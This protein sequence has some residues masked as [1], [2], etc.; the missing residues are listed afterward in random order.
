MAPSQSRHSGEHRQAA[1]P[2]AAIIAAAGVLLAGAALV[3]FLIR[4]EAREPELARIVLAQAPPA[5]NG[6]GGQ[7]KY[8]PASEEI[9]TTSVL[10]AAGVRVEPR[11][12]ETLA[13][14]ISTA[15]PGFGPRLNP[16]RS[17][18][19]PAPVAEAVEYSREPRLKPSG[20]RVGSAQGAD[21]EGA[22]A[23]LV[24][25]QKLLA[26]DDRRTP[27][28][29]DDETQGPVAP[30][31]SP[32]AMLAGD[33]DDAP[34]AVR[35]A[36]AKGENFVDALRRAGVRA[37]DR[38]A[39]AFAFGKLYDLR[40]MRPGQDL[41][42]T[43]AAPAQTLFQIV[44]EG[45][46]PETYLLALDFRID[47]EKRISLKRR[48]D[49]GFDGKSVAVALTSRLAS[50]SGR[51]N[52]SLYN[53]AK[54]IGAPDK[55]VADLAAI[56][57]YDV[58]FQ[59]EVFGGDEFEAVFEARYD[60]NGKLVEAGDILYGRMKWKGRQRE[61]GYY[62]FASADGGARADYF[63]WGGESAKRLLMKTPID[64]ARL[65][66]GFGARKH[67][68]SGFTKQHK[69]VD[70]AASRGT[71]IKAAGDGVIERADRYGGYGNY[72]RIRHGQGYK[73]AYGHMSGFAKGV[74]AGKRV[75][76]GDVIGYV[77]STGASTGPHLHYE[78]LLASKHVNPQ[79]LKVATGLSLGGA[80]LKKFKAARDVLDAARR[81]SDDE[82]G[83]LARDDAAAKQL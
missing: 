73:T 43:T 71:P 53:S 46:E 13:A 72:V 70:F 37:E 50:V 14:E 28:F 2:A 40:R 79:K 47:A 1:S 60:E 75:E 51:I 52:G 36:L 54:R 83:R 5:A 45:H 81:A 10:P 44:A 69:G 39:A 23:L 12:A 32:A 31:G 18:R 35:V 66:S 58:D 22:G 65:S 24:L 76:Q 64:G 77:G 17:P 78:V 15:D 25:G 20:A 80:D 11:P 74:R 30:I 62:R 56:F 6:S 59:R 34:Q 55:V 4:G 48:P 3:G 9:V 33:V 8:H 19:E 57:A 82:A 67:P 68:I 61:K 16:R 26:P 49:G 21:N 41:R 29:F 42:L 7:T 38:N 27:F 63:D